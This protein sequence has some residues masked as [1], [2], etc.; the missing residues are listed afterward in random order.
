[1]LKVLE[2]LHHWAPRR[3]AGMKARC[4]TGGYWEWFPV[5]DVIYITGICPINEYI[6][7]KQDTIAAQV[8]FRPIYELCK[9]EERMPR[10]FR[11]MRC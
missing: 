8:K 6:Q 10:Y 2:G 3:I 1:M 4:T 7:W 11:F 9:G 5:A